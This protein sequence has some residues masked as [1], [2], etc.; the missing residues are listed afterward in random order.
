MTSVF[1][2]RRLLYRFATTVDTPTNKTEYKKYRI[3]RGTPIIRLPPSVKFNI[4]MNTRW[5]NTQLRSQHF[6]N[7]P[8]RVQSPVPV[9]SF[10]LTICKY[11]SQEKEAVQAMVLVSFLNLFFIFFVRLTFGKINNAI[12]SVYIYFTLW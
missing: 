11:G 7:H 6:L 10:C 12:W 3:D 1:L 2:C 4:T 5:R 8:V 9:G